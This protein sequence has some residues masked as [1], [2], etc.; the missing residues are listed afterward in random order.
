M[1]T[2]PFRVITSKPYSGD[3]SAA[4]RARNVFQ[5][6]EDPVKGREVVVLYDPYDDPEPDGDYYVARV[7]WSKTDDSAMGDLEKLMIQ[8]S[9]QDSTG[10]P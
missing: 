10:Q 3:D 4:T 5:A 1:P 7:S 6:W 2:R 8:E 9:V